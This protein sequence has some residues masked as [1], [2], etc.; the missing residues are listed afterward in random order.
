MNRSTW[1]LALS[2]LGIGLALFT[3]CGG[4]ES[5]KQLS[6][7]CVQNSDCS[8]SLLCS[9]GHCHEQCETTKDCPSGARCVKVTQDE[10]VCQLPSEEGCEYNSDCAEPLACAL[11][12]ECR[13]QCKTD[14]DC[15]SGQVCTTSKVCA[16]PS[17]VGADNDL[18]GAGGAGA[19][20]G[21]S[22]G[23]N[24]GESG[25]GGARERGESS[26]AGTGHA[27][28]GGSAGG[29]GVTGGGGDGGLGSQEVSGAGTEGGVE[30][31][32]D[33]K[34]GG[35][36]TDGGADGT[37]HAGHSGSSPGGG[38]ATGGTDATG[39]ATGRAGG[40]GMYAAGGEGIGGSPSGGSSFGASGQAGAGGGLVVCGGEPLTIAYDGTA[41]PDSSG[42]A[43][44]FSTQVESGASWSSSGGELV[45]STTTSNAIWFGL[46]A[47]Y[48]PVSWS[49]APAGQGN[50]LSIRCKLGA[51]SEA[52]HVYFADDGRQIAVVYFMAGYVM[53]L[54]ADGDYVRHD[55]DTSTYH[56]YLVSTGNTSI[57]YSIDD[58][59]VLNQ[60]LPA[61]MPQDRYLII[62][63]GSGPSQGPFG[64]ETGSFYIDEAVIKTYTQ[65]IP[66]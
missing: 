15:V 10:N 22:P 46:H 49:L 34:G 4:N 42:F 23:G 65:C 58:V 50:S 25:S 38:S 29:P 63:D 62:G 66:E 19:E 59:E 12:G 3:G 17:E 52:F 1:F 7:G 60:E 30:G 57:S 43:A 51:S 35:A 21:A 14:R 24:A 6:D 37:G 56:S 45:L 26:D 11:D 33:A 48:D 54:D 8:G 27:G 32:G 31:T 5:K 40:A 20:G 55:V 39:G 18:L 61:P 13:N 16:E 44:V 64:W 2:T 36:G 28:M 41:T 9:F 53:L 47:T